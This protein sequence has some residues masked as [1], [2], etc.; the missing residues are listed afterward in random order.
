LIADDLVIIKPHNE[1]YRVYGTPFWDDLTNEGS[2]NARAE[3]SGL[4]LL[5]KDNENSL[6]AIDNTQAVSELYRNVLFFSDDGKLLSRVFRACCN[7]ANT[8]PV[9]QLHFR[10]D[11]SFW[12]LVRKQN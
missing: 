7:L 11:P 8:V 4:Y 2:D 3:L 9:Y 6:A 12:A 10:P 1:R 5:K